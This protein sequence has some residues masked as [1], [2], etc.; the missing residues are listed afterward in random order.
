MHKRSQTIPPENNNNEMKFSNTPRKRERSHSVSNKTSRPSFSPPESSTTLADTDRCPKAIFSDREEHLTRF[1]SAQLTERSK[2]LDRH[3]G[4]SWY[5]SNSDTSRYSE[6]PVHVEIPDNESHSGRFETATVKALDYCRKTVLRPYLIT[7]CLVGWKRLF[8]QSVKQNILQKLINILYPMFIISFL[9]MLYIASVYACK[10][11]AGGNSPEYINEVTNDTNITQPF[12]CQHMLS[13]FFIPYFLHLL[14]YLYALYSFRFN[15]NENIDS[16]MEMAFVL[17]ARCQ[18]V[19]VLNRN[20]LYSLLL[21]GL[22]CIIWQLLICIEQVIYIVLYVHCEIDHSSTI[23]ILTLVLN[24]SGAVVLKV[25]TGLVFIILILHYTTQCVLI[26]SLARGIKQGL[27]EKSTSLSFAMRDMYMCKTYLGR[28][29]REAANSVSLCLISII[30]YLFIDGVEVVRLFR[31]VEEVEHPLQIVYLVFDCVLWI[32]ALAIPLIMAARVQTEFTKLKNM[33]FGV[34]LFRYKDSTNEQ[35]NQ[36]FLYANS[37]TYKVRLF[38]VTVR[39]SFISLFFL[40]TF[41][42]IIVFLV[43]YSKI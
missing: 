4:F 18:H 33:T 26:I 19:L 28:L 21:I 37:I 6:G 8:S 9:I 5:S 16:L 29:N 1:M 22:L 12:H 31:H 15:S 7:L 36:F 23:N 2:I 34:Y 40:A 39:S 32:T 38:N 10:N 35:I 14:A 43:T 25:A 24:I 27:Q 17:A 11:G 3:N 30:I 41:F 20:I 13:L 42:A